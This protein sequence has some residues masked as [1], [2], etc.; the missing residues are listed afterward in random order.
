M[1]S[2]RLMAS[3]APRTTSGIKRIS[4]FWIENCRSLIPKRAAPC[5]LWV[6]SRHRGTSNQCPLYPQKRTSRSATGMSALCQIQTFC[7]AKRTSISEYKSRDDLAPDHGIRSVELIVQS[8]THYV[9]GE[10][11]VRSRPPGRT[12][13]CRDVECPQVEIKIF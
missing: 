4:R 7:T 8:K 3:P 13:R 2:R 9:V 6:K 1:N 11:N 5:P 12:Q 10:L